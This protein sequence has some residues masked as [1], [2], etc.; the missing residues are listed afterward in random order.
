MIYYAPLTD[1]A[2]FAVS[3]DDAES[4]LQGL[5][6]NDIRKA[7]EAQAIFAALLSPQGKFL[8]DFFIIRHKGKWLFDTDKARL[9]DLMKRLSMYRLRS[10]VEF[11]EMPELQVMAVWG[12][13]RGARHEVR[14]ISY[15]DPRVPE[16]GQRIL[17]KEIPAFAGM[18]KQEPGDY[19]RHRLTLSVPDGARDLIPDRS[20]PL[21]YGYDELNAIDFNKGCYVGQEVTARTKHR[22]T[23]RKFIH[24]VKAD[25]VLP[26]FGTP[27]MAAEREIGVMAGSNVQIGLALLRVE[28]AVRPLSAAGITLTASLPVWCSTSFVS[29]AK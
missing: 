10:K 17:D 5:I 21:E 25:A 6:T 26:P 14:G 2:V 8:Y 15:A 20:L 1:R 23:L 3:G 18:T 13:E 29:D 19:D 7:T 28:E 11:A 12:E 22:A 4:F 27:V 9:P 24:S 16:L